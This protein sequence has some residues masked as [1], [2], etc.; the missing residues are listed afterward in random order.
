MLDVLRFG[1]CLV[2]VLGHTTLPFFSQGWPNLIDWANGAVPGFFVLSGFVIRFVTA[3][4]ERQ[5]SRYWVSRASRMYSVVLP[6]IALAVVLD[7]ISRHANPAFYQSVIQPQ[8]WGSIPLRIVAELLFVTQTWGHAGLFLSNIPF[9]SLGY[10]VP[11]YVLFG[12]ATFTRGA[13][14]AA[15][16]VAAALVFGPQVLFL[17]PVWWSGIWLYDA[18]QWLRQP[19]RSAWVRLAAISGAVA[20]I[21]WLLLPITAGFTRMQSM[22]NPLLLLHLQVVRASMFEYA[23]GLVSWAVLLLLLC[24]S[25]LMLLPKKTPAARAI[26]RIAESTFTLYLFHYPM[27]V[28]AAALHLYRPDHAAD[29]IALMGGITLLCIVAAV[30]IEYFKRWLR[31]RMSPPHSLCPQRYS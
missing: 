12:I 27:L 25:D 15:L 31:D 2:V 20:V 6:A 28:C 24:A 1:L 30:P 14:R 5:A 18:W 21:A 17:L 8:P 4:R 7:A 11:Y 10:E 29:K 22:T 19:G 3:T 16:L 9:W 23:A 13:R 26:R